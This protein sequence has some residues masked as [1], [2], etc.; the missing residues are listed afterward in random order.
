MARYLIERSLLDE[1]IETVKTLARVPVI[2]VVKADGYGF[3]MAFMAMRL[4]EHGV[5]MFAIT[6]IADIAPLRATVGSDDVLMMRS[7]ALAEELDEVLRG[8]CIA[9]IGSAHA[10]AA[11]DEAARR[12]GVRARAHIK[13]DTGFSRYGFPADDAAGIIGCFEAE[14][15]RIEGM[16]THFS[17][18]YADRAVTARQLACLERAA[19]AVR[20]AGYDPGMLHAANSPALLNFADE[21]DVRLDAVRIGSAFTGR[22]MTLG[23]TALARVGFLEARVIDVKELP[24]GA[25][26]GY[27]G[28][29]QTKRPTRL[30]FVSAGLRD[31]FGLVARSKPTLRD[32]LSIVRHL[33]DA[34]GLAVRIGERSYPLLGEADL[35]T[36]YVDVTG[37]EVRIGDAVRLDPN[38][39]MVPSSVPREYV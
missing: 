6:E 2:G 37:G 10:L 21:L 5:R 38:P 39:L 3:G 18:A 8:E 22:V 15:V 36:C 24:A 32:A 35:S 20:S 13:I 4:R 16:Y 14:S 7:T 9:T 28:L 11:L 34:G 29:V 27:G 25:R 26:I 33:K 1:N 30:A 12:R 17:Q 31:G 23:E 19:E